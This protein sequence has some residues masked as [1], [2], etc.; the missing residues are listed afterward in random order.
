[1]K[2]NTHNQDLAFKDKH[3]HEDC[4]LCQRCAKSMVDHPF[5]SKGDAL[6]CENCYEQQFSARCEKCNEPFKSGKVF[7]HF[8]FHENETT[9]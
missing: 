8:A 1:V 2:Q 6:F 5:A 4:F 7:L 9:L 3:W